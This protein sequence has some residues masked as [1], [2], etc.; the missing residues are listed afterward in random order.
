MVHYQ[1]LF[2]FALS[3]TIINV[4]YKILGE[5]YA[6]DLPGKRKHHAVALPQIGGLFFGPVILFFSWLYGLVPP[7]YIIG[8]VVTILLGGIDD[9]FK[10]PWAVKLIIQ[11]LLCIY[12]SI[13][14]WAQFDYIIFYNH[15]FLFNKV[16]LF[17]LFL[18]WFVGIY[19]SVN[20]IDGLDGLAGGYIFIVSMGLAVSNLGIHSHLNGLI[21]VVILAFLLFNQRPAKLFMGD[22]GSLFLG[23]H[24]AV[25]PLLFAH[26]NPTLKSLVIT[27]YI[28]L[29]SYLIADTSRVFFT[30]LVDKKNPMTADTIHFHHLI[31]QQSGSYLTSLFT[32]YFITAISVITAFL[33][34]NELLSLNMIFVHMAFLLIFILTPPVETY[35][36]IINKMII[37]FYEWH[38]SFL[39]RNKP[40]LLRTLV[41]LG[42]LIGLF[43]SIIIDCNDFFKLFDWQYLTTFILLFIFIKTNKRDQITMYTILLTLALL[44]NDILWGIEISIIHK[45]FIIFLS[46]SYIIFTFERRAGSII[47]DL[48]SLDLLL[49]IFSLS[50]IFLSIF[51]LQQYFWYGLGQFSIWSSTSFI[52]RRTY[53]N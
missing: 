3:L 2:I 25:L 20:L 50:S 17:V 33:S 16:T 36:P 49:F 24:I 10:V 46:I 19:N 44:Y 51:D 6:L 27:P 52:M 48:S 47:S 34:I 15:S 45:L 40:S 12:L 23:Y 29:A 4:L 43:I 30:R 13:L 26:N 14:F 39:G 11:I 8:G 7:W 21:T 18:I 22:A 42:L 9:R 53:F 35:V 5:N 38:K 28:L 37:P 31:L 32:I 41:M 1:S